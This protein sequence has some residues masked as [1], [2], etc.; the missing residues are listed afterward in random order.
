MPQYRCTVCKKTITYTKTDNSFHKGHC[1]E[2][3]LC[4]SV[5][6]KNRYERNIKGTTTIFSPMGLAL[7]DRIVSEVIKRRYILENPDEK[8]IFLNS[9]F[10]FNKIKEKYRPAKIFWSDITL[11][12]TMPKDVIWFSICNEANEYARQGY[13]PQLT[14]RYKSVEIKK[15]NFVKEDYIVFHIRNIERSKDKNEKP[16]IA[17]NILSYLTKAGFKIVLIGNDERLGFEDNYNIVDLRN[18]LKLEQ[19]AWVCDNAKLYCG[20]DS[21]LAHLAGCTSASLVVWDFASPRWYP[22]TPNP[23]ITIMRQNTNVDNILHAINRIL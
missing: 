22:K 8:V 12:K 10:D 5:L 20:K 23:M 11:F 14:F 15:I 13:Y 2:C 3:P 19:I 17:N 18:K 6:A 16:E 7:G 1:W 4:Y 21:G 9:E